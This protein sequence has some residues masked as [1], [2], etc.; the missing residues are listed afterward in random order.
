MT[1]KT[2]TIRSVA[3][4]M[5]FG[6]TLALPTVAFADDVQL[7]SYDGS[8]TMTGT[9]LGYEDSIYV[10]G[11]PLGELHIYALRMSCEGAACPSMAQVT[12][13]LE[14]DGVMMMT[15]TALPDGTITSDPTYCPLTGALRAAS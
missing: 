13:D 4:A 12:A 11:T 1:F 6:V 5:T 2:S 3:K 7:K 8:T 9:L 14:A 15:P 10:L